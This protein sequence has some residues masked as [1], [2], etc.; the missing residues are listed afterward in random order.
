MSSQH[1]VACGGVV[2]AFKKLLPELKQCGHQW[3]IELAV[4]PHT[5]DEK[6]A[7]IV[8]KLGLGDHLACTL[9]SWGRNACRKPSF[10]TY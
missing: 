1:S 4:G 5:P 10:E 9:A 7:A 3:K 8:I 6:V 2:G